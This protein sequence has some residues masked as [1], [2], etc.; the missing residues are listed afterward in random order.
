MHEA[1]WSSTRHK[2]VGRSID[3]QLLIPSVSVE[4]PS[5][6]E[7]RIAQSIMIHFLFVLF[8]I[9]LILLFVYVRAEGE[10]KLSPLIATA[11]AVAHWSLFGATG[12]ELEFDV[13]LISGRAPPIE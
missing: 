12:L 8:C 3:N 10:A 2:V 7:A 6:H 5:I 9:N 13:V 4:Y 11:A 1:K